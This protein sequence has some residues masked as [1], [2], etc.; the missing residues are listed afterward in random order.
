[1]FNQLRIVKDICAE[2]SVDFVN[3]VHGSELS[4][5]AFS[6]WVTRGRFLG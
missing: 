3:G 5:K 6:H 4:L 1:M 2:E